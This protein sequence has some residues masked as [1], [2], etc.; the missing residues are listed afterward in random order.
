MN[1]CLVDETGYC[2]THNCFCE[3][4]PYGE[5]QD[6]PKVERCNVCND[7]PCQIGDTICEDCFIKMCQDLEKEKTNDKY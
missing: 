1:K 3:N 7:N 5:P 2:E 6:I 4:L